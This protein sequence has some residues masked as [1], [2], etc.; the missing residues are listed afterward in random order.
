VDQLYSCLDQGID[1]RNGAA[2]GLGS[3]EQSVLPADG[4]HPLILPMSGRMWKSITDGIRFL[5]G[6]C[7]SEPNDDPSCDLSYL[8]DLS[9]EIARLLGCRPVPGGTPFRI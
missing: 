9:L 8:T 4:Y 1:G 2:T 5:A 6:R 7:Y 3:G